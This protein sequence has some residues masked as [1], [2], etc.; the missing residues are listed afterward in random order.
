[1]GT[2]DSL[3]F[4][5]DDF[6][7]EKHRFLHNQLTQKGTPV[8]TTSAAIT[9]GSGFYNGGGYVDYPGTIDITF[10]KRFAATESK[11]VVFGSVGAFKNTNAGNVFIGLRISGTDYG[12]GQFFFNTTGQHGLIPCQ[13]DITGIAAG[14][15][16]GRVRWDS[17]NISANADANDGVRLNIM[18]VRI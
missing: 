12:I 6:T 17:A 8:T 3:V 7:V 1:M 4:G 15:F 16:V 2:F 11:L 9:S 18:E 10:I 13:T 5:Q 14:T